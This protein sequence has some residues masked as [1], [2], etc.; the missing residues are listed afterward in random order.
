M[1]A[2]SLSKGLDKRLVDAARRVANR[3]PKHMAKATEK[4]LIDSLENQK[5]ETE[6]A[7]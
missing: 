2:F 3:M 7:K 1:F 4:E 6:K 5:K